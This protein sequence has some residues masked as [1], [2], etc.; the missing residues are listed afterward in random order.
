MRNYFDCGPVVQEMMSFLFLVGFLF[1]ALVA[2]LF[3]NKSE[4]VCTILVENFKLNF[5]CYF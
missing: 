5:F 4:T 3:I 2:I 1:L